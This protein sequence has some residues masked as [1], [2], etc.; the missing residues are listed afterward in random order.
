M[1]SVTLTINIKHTLLVIVMAGYVKSNAYI[2][3]ENNI[4][5]NMS[6]FKTVEELLDQISWRVGH[7]MVSLQSCLWNEI[8]LQRFLCSQCQSHW[9]ILLCDCGLIVLITLCHPEPLTSNIHLHPLYHKHLSNFFSLNQH[10]NE[11][12]QAFGHYNSCTSA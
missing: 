11:R 5:H 2:S 12:R 3:I 6:I 10:K 1:K 4:F 8:H 9:H 7:Y